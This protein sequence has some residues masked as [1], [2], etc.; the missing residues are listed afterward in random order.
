MISSCQV[1]Q[2]TG[3]RIDGYDMK[4]PGKH[5]LLVLQEGAVTSCMYGRVYMAW[6][7][8]A[9]VQEPPG[10]NHSLGWYGSSWLPGPVLAHVPGDM[11]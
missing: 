1:Q 7:G 10:A 11:G 8:Y 2:H 3:W 5:K 6:D 9:S 4:L